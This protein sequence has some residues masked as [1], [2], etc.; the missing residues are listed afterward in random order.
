MQTLD[1]KLLDELAHKLRRITSA[2]LTTEDEI[3][4]TTGVH[5]STVSRAMNRNLKRVTVRVKRLIR[6]ANMRVKQN[7]ISEDVTKTACQFY[8]AGGSEKEL[9]ASIEHAIDL[10]S[11]R[12]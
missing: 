3:G 7:E 9:V 1:D 11:R 5:Q 8:A 12:L 6:Y 10:V 2:K 4:R